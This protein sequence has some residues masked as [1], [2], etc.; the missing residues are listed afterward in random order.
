MMIHQLPQLQS[1]QRNILVLFNG[2]VLANAL[3]CWPVIFIS[4]VLLMFYTIH[5]DFALEL[6]GVQQVPTISTAGSLVPESMVFTFGLH[7]S[8][9][10]LLLYFSFIHTAFRNKIIDLGGVV[11]VADIERGVE[12]SSVAAMNSDD[13]TCTTSCNQ[14]DIAY[15]CYVLCW[16]CCIGHVYRTPRYLH[17]WNDTLLYL[18][19]LTAV[20]MAVTGSVPISDTIVAQNIVHGTA[21]FFMFF[22]GVLHMLCMYLTIMER[23]GYTH[24]QLQYH[25]I[26]LFVCIPLNVIMLVIAGIVFASCSAYSCR[27]FAVDIGSILEYTTVLGLLLYMYRFKEDVAHITLAEVVSTLSTDVNGNSGSSNGSN[28]N[29]ALQQEQQDQQSIERQEDSKVAIQREK[30]LNHENHNVCVHSDD[31]DNGND[32]PDNED[33]NNDDVDASN[34]TAAAVDNEAAH[35]D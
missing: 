1:Q 35:N 28:S 3:L 8:A 27:K 23:T 29:P 13:T 24:R 16:G 2:S 31:H 33:N 5:P 10:L 19:L 9:M 34:R 11:A 20:L 26:A 25:R 22:G 15:S 21:A 18:G 17:F 12:E 4:I 32:D 7:V 30:T 14:A 6:E